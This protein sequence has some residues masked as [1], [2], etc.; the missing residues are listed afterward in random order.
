M[1]IALFL[2]LLLNSSYLISQ[3]ATISGRVVDVNNTPISFVNVLVFEME[4]NNPIAGTTTAE[5]GTFN[6]SNLK[7]Q[8]YKITFSF[9]GFDVLEQTFI[10]GS[11]KDLGVI[12]IKESQEILNEAIVNVRRPS[13][14]KEPGKLT[15]NVENT[16]LS[17]GNTFELLMKTPGV[18]VLGESI[19]IKSTTPIIFIN[20][21]RVYLSPSETI[22]LLQNVDASLIKSVEVITNPNSKFDAE[23]GTALNIILSKA[24]SI[25]YKGSINGT[26][27]QAV[28]P[29][30][31]LG[32]AHFYKNK[33]LNFYGSY[34]YNER[35]E[36]KHDDNN[37][38]F[39]EP[40]GDVKSFWETDFNKRTKSYGHQGNFVVDMDL[41]EKHNI[42]ISANIF[43]SPNKMFTNHVDAQIYSAQQQLDSTFVT[44]SNL[45]N[46]TSNLSFNLKHSWKLG[47]A[48]ANVVMDANYILYDNEQIQNVNTN[49]YLPNGDF[50]QNNSFFTFANQNSDIITGQ[51]DFTIPALS[52]SIETGF[53]Y[54]NI[55]TESG[56][57]FFE[58]ENDTAQINESLSDLFNYEES[59]LAGYFNFSREWEKWQINVGVRGENTDI[60]GNSREL[61]VVNVQEYFELFPSSSIQH[62]INDNNNIGLSYVRR[63]ERPR[64]QSLNPFKYFINENNFNGG[65]PNLVPAIGN[66]YTISYSYKNKWFF[67]AYY[68]KTHNRLSILTF[69]DNTNNTLRN[70]DSNLIK[71]FNYSFDIV[72]ASPLFSWWYLSLY[73][74]TFYEENELL[75]V[76]SV[77]KTYSN[78][79]VGFYAQMYN[80]LTISNKANLTSDVTLLYISNT[81]H[82][83]YDYK[84]MLNLSVSIKK[85]FWNRR[86]SVTAGVND[87]FNTYNVPVTS[88]YY[89]QDNSYFAQDESRLFTLG[90]KYNFG[91]ARLRDN[92]RKPSTDEGNRL[93]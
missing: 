76:E 6:I 81:I 22:L 91:N 82:G 41:N 14:K 21:K 39:F 15:F 85:E 83:S 54:S 64:Y 57:D 2:L 47:E 42:G 93:N 87:I 46:D 33:W 67:E 24:I 12:I 69:Q 84:N 77:E 56:L 43:A 60:Q 65:N 34:N 50:L 89:N 27:E 52:G 19:K 73:T 35:K 48:G 62:T 31:N 40:N 51:L 71:D 45:E 92:S 30:Y 13:I 53:K 63:I 16:S 55:N 28:F 61:G 23:A 86:A 26:Y 59:I 1:R 10:A 44:Q 70:V 90:F 74:S 29:K 37:I 3:N 80:G 58:T 72:Y 49:Y 25:G 79:T 20:G 32:T 66:K 75:A 36:Y 5:D 4:S 17:S 18:S 78:H 68:I 8:Q 11:K 9:V 38:K 88:R 7:E